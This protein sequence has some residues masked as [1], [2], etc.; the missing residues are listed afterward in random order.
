MRL[1]HIEIF[2][3][4]RRTGSLT[5]AA[6]AL[7][8]SQPAASKL[9]ANAEAQ[10]GFPLFE[11]IK[12]RLHPTVEADVLAP[13]VSRLYQELT[14]VRRLASNLRQGHRGHLRVGTPPALGLGLLPGVVKSM[15][16]AHPGITVE[17]N[18]HHSEELIEGLL[19]RSLDLIV[20]FDAADHPGIKR[21]QVGATELVHVGAAGPAGARRLA[22]LQGRPFI[23]LDARDPSGAALQHAVDVAG[24]ELA[25]VAQVQTHYVAFALAE[26]GCG[27]ALVDLIT[28][29]AMLRP[30]MMLSRLAPPIPVPVNVMI[31]AAT[32]VSKLHRAF[33][34]TVS[35]ACATLGLDAGQDNLSL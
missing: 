12:G 34:D 15:L 9:L 18:T 3:A 5:D 20:T 2:E 30:G 14:N 11:R 19:T 8:V 4:I 21:E 28:A 29:R 17:L 27:D 7:H 33:I 22:D 31:H 10:L 16:D 23:A 6:A 32:P 13:Q 26:A 1:R 35:R 25:I 24:I